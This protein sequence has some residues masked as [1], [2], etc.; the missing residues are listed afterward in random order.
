[1]TGAKDLTGYIVERRKPDSDDWEPVATLPAKVTSHHL[2][3]LPEGAMYY[4][5]V[6]SQNSAGKS[7][8]TELKTP[9][10]LKG[11]RGNEFIVYLPD[12][13]S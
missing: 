10:E 7:R 5:R 4:F 12:I 9:V 8:P 2:D 6:A 13:L 3:K 11:R 1:M